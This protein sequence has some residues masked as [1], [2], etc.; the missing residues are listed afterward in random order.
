MKNIILALAIVFCSG[1]TMIQKQA[2]KAEKKYARKY[3]DGDLEKKLNKEVEKGNLTPKQA[4]EILKG[5]IKF[6]EWAEK[7]ADRLLKEQEEMEDKEDK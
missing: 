3:L 1:C 7:R 4:G 6:L 5:G 2:W